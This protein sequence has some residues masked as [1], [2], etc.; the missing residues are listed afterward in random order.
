MNHNH[1][2][3]LNIACLDCLRA[4]MRERD[5]LLHFTKTVAGYLKHK[6]D[7]DYDLELIAVE[8]HQLLK[9]LGFENE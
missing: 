1:T 5:R 7:I 8:A 3:K 9:E 6:N 4:R 2:H